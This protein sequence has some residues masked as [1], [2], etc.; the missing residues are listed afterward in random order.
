MRGAYLVCGNDIGGSR[1]GVGSGDS[2]DYELEV[3]QNQNASPR[4]LALCV[5]ID[6]IHEFLRLNK[7]PL[8]NMILHKWDVETNRLEKTLADSRNL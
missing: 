8:A 4:M 5:M 6:E 2:N 7:S 1:G 3:G